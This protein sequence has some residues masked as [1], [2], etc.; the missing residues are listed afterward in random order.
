M[1][2]RRA[3]D[4]VAE[5]VAT[6]AEELRERKLDDAD[7]RE[8]AKADEQD[9]AKIVKARETLLALENDRQRKYAARQSR[10][11]TYTQA[12]DRRAARQ[13]EIEPA[14]YAERREQ[15]RTEAFERT[16]EEEYV[17]A[18]IESVQARQ[19]AARDA[20]RQLDERLLEGVTDP[21]KLPK[22]D[23]LPKLVRREPVKRAWLW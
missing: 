2:K 3:A 15:F 18:T 11:Y 20:L 12:R 21:G 4:E 6:G 8:F 7:A 14:V 1:R 23:D 22:I 13:R 16:R 9:L 10:A 19:A 17:S 5:F